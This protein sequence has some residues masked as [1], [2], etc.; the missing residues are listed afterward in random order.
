MSK[1][2]RHRG[3]WRI[4]WKDADGKR[5][6]EVHEE[7][8][9]AERQLRK[10]QV[11]ADEIKAGDKPKPPPERT[12]ADL[13]DF[14]L[15]TSRAKAKRSYKDDVSICRSLKEV[16]GHLKLAELGREDGGYY[17]DERDDIE[18]KTIANLG[19]FFSRG[20]ASRPP[21][22]PRSWSPHSAMRER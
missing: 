1:P 7:Y 18:A 14:W 5:C 10:P 20:S 9:E 22:S 8:N 11:E 16:L 12:V 21:R 2:V 4:R 19:P 3:K 13:C 15:E 6:S 17:A